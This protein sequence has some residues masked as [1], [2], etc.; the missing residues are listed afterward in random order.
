MISLAAFQR[1]GLG[2]ADSAE[3]TKRGPLPK[4]LRTKTAALYHSSVWHDNVTRMFLRA[5]VGLYVYGEI[6]D[7]HKCALYFCAD[8]IEEERTFT[9]V[10]KNF[11]A[12]DQASRFL[13]VRFRRIRTKPEHDI[14]N[15]LYDFP[16]N[17]QQEATTTDSQLALELRRLSRFTEIFQTLTCEHLMKPTD[18]DHHYALSIPSP[19]PVWNVV[20]INS[21]ESGI[22]SKRFRV[23]R[24]NV[25]QKFTADQRA[26]VIPVIFISRKYEHNFVPSA[27]L[28]IDRDIKNE[29]KM[30][31]E[32]KEKHKERKWVSFTFY[33]KLT[34]Y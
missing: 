26:L 11:W 2:S 31:K 10:M 3:L 1:L 16:Y 13:R 17:Q 23:R 20:K 21:V 24:F 14:T 15:M 12:D 22:I 7:C 32:L 28:N 18:D 27:Y 6:D 8:T 29:A 25:V 30:L 19:D 34:T 5:L 4:L 9:R 33:L